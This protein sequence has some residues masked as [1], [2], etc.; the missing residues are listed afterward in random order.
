M[1]SEVAMVIRLTIMDDIESEGHSVMTPE[2]RT[3][4]KDIALFSERGPA[5]TANWSSGYGEDIFQS[6]KTEKAD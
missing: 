3:A 5:I 1:A 4:M 2:I 6:I